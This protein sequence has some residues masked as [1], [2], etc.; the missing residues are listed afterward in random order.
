MSHEA[1]VININLP[2]PFPLGPKFTI[3][4]FIKKK[5]SKVDEHLCL[6][7]ILEVSSNDLTA[8]TWPNNLSLWLNTRTHYIN[9]SPPS[10]K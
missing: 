5:G 7:Q 4:K 1:D 10:S 8:T 9:Q 2:F 3:K 6:H